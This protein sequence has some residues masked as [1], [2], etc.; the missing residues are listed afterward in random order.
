[1]TRT[2][3]KLNTKRAD[4]RRATVS[5]V[6]S[7]STPVQVRSQYAEQDLVAWPALFGILEQVQTDQT[8]S[9]SSPTTQ[10]D[11]VA[12]A[13]RGDDSEQTGAKHYEATENTGQPGN[14]PAA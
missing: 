3:T 8:V 12:P 6:S 9:R 4:L 1:M 14:P 13:P 10:V 2:Q 7:E 11:G 5:S